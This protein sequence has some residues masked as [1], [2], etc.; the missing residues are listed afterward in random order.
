MDVKASQMY[1]KLFILSWKYS[2]VSTLI[3]FLRNSFFY[4]FWYERFM[5]I[6]SHKSWWLLSACLSLHLRF[7]LALCGFGALH[8]RPPMMILG[9]WYNLLH[10]NCLHFFLRSWG[11]H[12]GRSV[13]IHY[14]VLTLCI[15]YKN[16]L[17]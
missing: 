2:H 16:L 3:L 8:Y 9:R 4:W 15:Y 11:G 13:T 7:L 14:L 17:I 5:S 1:L 10:S 6:I 12:F